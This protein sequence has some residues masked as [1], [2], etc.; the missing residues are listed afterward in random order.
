MFQF[1]SLAPTRQSFHFSQKLMLYN[2]YNGK[3]HI[4]LSFFSF[5]PFFYSTCVCLLSFIC[6]IL[7]SRTVSLV[8]RKV[9]DDAIFP[10]FLNVHT[11][12]RSWTVDARAVLL[13]LD[14]GKYTEKKCSRSEWTNVHEWQRF[15][16]S[17]C[18]RFFAVT[19]IL[20]FSLSLVCVISSH[21]SAEDSADCSFVAVFNSTVCSKW[22]YVFGK[23]QKKYLWCLLK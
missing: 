18:P 8:V 19:S 13:I 7:I 16:F 15:F 12:L 6:Y 9:Y 10:A 14:D 1:F 3:L 11:F 4:P 2:V 20:P 22:M 21:P 5:F 17:F 23:V